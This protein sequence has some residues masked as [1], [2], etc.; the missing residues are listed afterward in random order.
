[1][2]ENIKSYNSIYQLRE[3]FKRS[4]GHSDIYAKEF[5]RM[6]T[7]ASLYFRLFFHFN[8]GYGL[9]NTGKE[10]I[11]L[12]STR[13]SYTENT[14]TAVS[15]L[16][17]NG[18][19]QRKQMLDDFVT[20]FSNINTYSPWYF[21]SI[22]GLQ[23]ALQRSEYTGEFK[24]DEEPKSITI[25]TLEDPYDNRISTLLDLYKAVAFSKIQHKEILPANLRRF[26]MSIYLINTP[27]AYV[28]YGYGDWD[29]EKER[30]GLNGQPPVSLTDM[31]D[32]EVIFD[33]PSYREWASGSNNIFS[34][35]KLI[36][37]QGCEIDANSA[38]SAYTEI[39]SDE[40]F[41]MVHEIKIT[42]KN[43]IEQR[44]NDH[45]NRIIGDYIFMD[46]DKEDRQSKE[47]VWGEADVTYHAKDFEDTI[48]KY[49]TL[50][51]QRGSE[52][53]LLLDETDDDGNP[54][55]LY[56]I[57]DPNDA[58]NEYQAMIDENMMRDETLARDAAGR[59]LTADSALI[60]LP[61]TQDM[62][63]RWDITN[64]QGNI[65]KEKS[66]LKEAGQNI[67]DKYKP[68]IINQITQ[69]FLKGVNTGVKSG[70]GSAKKR[71]KNLSENV[72]KPLRMVAGR[73]K[74]M[75]ERFK[76]IGMRLG[77]IVG[78]KLEN[79]GNAAV[80]RIFDPMDAAVNRSIARTG[81]ILDAANALSARIGKNLEDFTANAADKTLEPFDKMIDKGSS[82]IGKTLGGA[83]DKL[84]EITNQGIEKL[85]S[86]AVGTPPPSAPASGGSNFSG[87]TN[88][89]KAAQRGW[90]S[91]G[92]NLANTGKS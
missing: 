5:N 29:R 4:G 59:I 52:I 69:D 80:N 14:N 16:Y 22:D 9:L 20:L 68:G 91:I 66:K 11:D 44:F 19:L 41:H 51:D 10:F 54:I 37:L 64:I 12:D 62:A 63:S 34:S 57:E 58:L 82:L 45:L 39:K 8:T 70:A 13:T 36:E 77:S 65:Y 49:K 30:H 53:P 90:S 84:N 3:A 76:T 7:P 17:V 23:E 71:L 61:K 28:H 87:S 88:N 43:I 48:K 25:K 74:E 46:M 26:D 27:V 85:G 86:I 31:G 2:Q 18:E 92:T 50:S 47:N 1:M 67:I 83:N 56:Q 33:I 81:S 78:S 79:F 38:A 6:E 24:I 21:Q 72:W 89:D 60:P 35:A 55:E 73:P 42:Y 75:S 32:P 40:P 15:Y